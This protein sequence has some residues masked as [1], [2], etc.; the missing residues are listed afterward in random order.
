MMYIYNY[1]HMYVCIYY[2]LFN[3]FSNWYTNGI[4][5]YNLALIVFFDR[6]CAYLLTIKLHILIIMLYITYNYIY[7][8][9]YI[10]ITDTKLRTLQLSLNMTLACSIH[11]CIS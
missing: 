10:C 7:F 2:L 1:T 4:M 9:M 6:L 8:C 3:I 11:S 5:V